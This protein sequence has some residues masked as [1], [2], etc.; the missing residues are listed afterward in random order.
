MVNTN[1]NRNNNNNNDFQASLGAVNS[2]QQSSQ[3]TQSTTTMTMITVTPI[4][5]PIVVPIG[6]TAAKICGDHKIFGRRRR[7]SSLYKLNGT[8]CNW[9]TDTIFPGFLPFKSCTSEM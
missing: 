9:E 5:I 3:A 7:K 1:N 4:G 6:K 8:N 2:N